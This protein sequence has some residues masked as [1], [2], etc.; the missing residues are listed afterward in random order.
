[1]ILQ[2][3]KNYPNFN[4]NQCVSFEIEKLIKSFGDEI[5]HQFFVDYLVQTKTLSDE[6]IEEKVINVKV[7]TLTGKFISV[8]G[9]NTRKNSVLDL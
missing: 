7:K 4:A 5:G 9:L 3:N 1:M 8:E 2:E 6:F